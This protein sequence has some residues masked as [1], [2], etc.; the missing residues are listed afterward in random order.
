MRCLDVWVEVALIGRNNWAYVS[1]GTW[2]P[3]GARPLELSGE[4][5][6]D[7]VAGQFASAHP[8]AKYDVGALV[9]YQGGVQFKM[10][11]LQTAN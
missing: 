8:L 7:I 2:V 1:R 6:P 10:T 4:P 11:F 9:T 3:G 5:I